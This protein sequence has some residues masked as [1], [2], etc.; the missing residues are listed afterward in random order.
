[1]VFFD[2]LPYILAILFVAV[3]VSQC[4]L[5]ELAGRP[6]FPLFRRGWKLRAEISQA[7]EHASVKTLEQQL[8]EM[9]HTQGENS[10]GVFNDENK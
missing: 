10:N 7:R 8:H 9:K 3:L 1:M 5:P 4:L 2:F 6:W